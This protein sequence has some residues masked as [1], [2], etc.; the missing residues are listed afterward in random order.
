MIRIQVAKAYQ[1]PIRRR[2]SWFEQHFPDS[3]AAMRKHLALAPMAWILSGFV[4]CFVVR[5]QYPLIVGLVLGCVVM[6]SRWAAVFIDALLEHPRYTRRRALRSAVPCV[7]A[8]LFVTLCGGE[9]LLS[10]LKLT[11]MSNVPWVITWL[12]VL[13]LALG[14]GY[15][16]I[17]S[18][19]G[20]L[21]K[22]S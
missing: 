3:A 13:A 16:I 4:I 1:P 10:E 17:R 14:R 19:G 12:I 5:K 8:L 15:W 6:A 18:F 9:I 21:P 22:S 20:R 2:P 7:F 11:Q